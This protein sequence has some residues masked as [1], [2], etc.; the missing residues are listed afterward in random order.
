MDKRREVAQN[1]LKLKVDGNNNILDSQTNEIIGELCMQI[2][3]TRIDDETMG[4]KVEQK[5]V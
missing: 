5:E 1:M 3:E 4:E 2:D